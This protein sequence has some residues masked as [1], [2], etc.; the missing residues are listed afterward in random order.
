MISELPL[1]PDLTVANIVEIMVA[2]RENWASVA[3]YNERIPRLR[4]RDLEAAEPVG[5]PA[6]MILAHM[7]NEIRNTDLDERNSGGT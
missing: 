5:T 2:S 4:K 3:N 1:R 7:L 6:Y